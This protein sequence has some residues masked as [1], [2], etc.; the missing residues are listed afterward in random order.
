MSGGGGIKGSSRL[1]SIGGGVGSTGEGGAGGFVGGGMVVPDTDGGM[2]ALSCVVLSIFS[3]TWSL[4]S[5]G[6]L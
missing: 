1:E 4:V 3:A 2:Y 6:F 5:A